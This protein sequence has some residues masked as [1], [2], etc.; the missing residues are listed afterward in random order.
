MSIRPAAARQ[1][2]TALS[3]NANGAE[4]AGAPS[5]PGQDTLPP[6]TTPRIGPRPEVLA[7]YAA[8]LSRDP[9]DRRAIIACLFAAGALA[10]FMLAAGGLTAAT[11]FAGLFGILATFPG[12]IAIF[13]REH[14]GRALDA[15]V[16]G[17]FCIHMSLILLW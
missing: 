9:P 12:A 10:A 6:A 1:T 16:V 7:A 4:N 13:R 3:M 14:P 2:S 17:L 15:L 8:R 11:P 5:L